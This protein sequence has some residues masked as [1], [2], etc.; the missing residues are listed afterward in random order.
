VGESFVVDG[1]E[2]GIDRQRSHF[3]VIGA[4]TEEVRLD[5]KIV[6]DREM[7][8]RLTAWL[9]DETDAEHYARPWAWTLYPPELYIRDC[10]L[11]PAEPAGAHEGQVCIDDLD[12]IEVFFYAMSHHEVD[13]VTLRVAPEGLTVRGVVCLQG[14]R[15]PF[16]IFLGTE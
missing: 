12:D 10:P 6:G 13:D 15:L 14:S 5:A 3:R 16:A 2:L 4:G 1:T 11:R 7:H 8:E 9:P